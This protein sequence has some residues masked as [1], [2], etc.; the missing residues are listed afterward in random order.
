MMGDS[1]W[2]KCPLRRLGWV[3]DGMTRGGLGYICGK[4]DAACDPD[5]CLGPD[6]DLYK[7]TISGPVYIDEFIWDMKGDKNEERIE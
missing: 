7:S 6:E 4:N 3:D 1:N 5:Y 2:G